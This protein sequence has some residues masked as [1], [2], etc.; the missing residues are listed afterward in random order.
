MKSHTHGWTEGERINESQVLLNLTNVRGWVNCITRVSVVLMLQPLGY[1]LEK[2]VSMMY[3]EMSW[4]QD[5]I[6][7]YQLS[8][9]NMSIECV[10]DWSS[11]YPEPLPPT[12]NTNQGT[13]DYEGDIN[14]LL[15]MSSG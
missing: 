10:Y 12:D 1:P 2:G 8:T 14:I 6:G 7:L 15:V 3:F 9:I 13:D 11:K 4:G 5:P